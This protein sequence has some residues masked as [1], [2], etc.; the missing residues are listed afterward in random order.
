M[1]P[2]TSGDGGGAM[3]KITINNNGTPQDYAIESLTRE[4]GS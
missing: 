3:P 4:E 2:L 1:T